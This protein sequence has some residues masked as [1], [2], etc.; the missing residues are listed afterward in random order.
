ME[1]VATWD[2]QS[3]SSRTLQMDRKT[4]LGTQV[5]VLLDHLFLRTIRIIHALKTGEL[6]VLVI[7]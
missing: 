4:Q 2:T 5:F 1:R 6:F 3:V 7:T